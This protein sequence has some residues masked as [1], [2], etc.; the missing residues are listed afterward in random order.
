ML[1]VV[2]PGEWGLALRLRLRLFAAP[3]PSRLLAGCSFLRPPISH[4]PS[5]APPPTHSRGCSATPSPPARPHPPG[6]LRPFDI[7]PPHR[8]AVI[9]CAA[10]GRALFSP[11]RLLR[12]PAPT[13]EGNRL[14]D[15]IPALRSKKR[16]GSGVVPWTC[17]QRA[18][19]WGVSRRRRRGGTCSGN[20]WEGEGW[21]GG[22]K[23]GGEGG[24]DE[25][26]GERPADGG[27]TLRRSRS[28]TPH[29][30][31]RSTQRPDARTSR[32]PGL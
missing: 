29:S 15:G 18:G 16:T 1:V 11:A 31:D 28:E 12:R 24:S 26:E 22:G 7:P 30:P 21:K 3:E 9:G 32:A 17:M 20:G 6:P 8:S 27:R 13:S 4:S 10:A 23:T 14:R 5:T 2:G 25:Q 19:E